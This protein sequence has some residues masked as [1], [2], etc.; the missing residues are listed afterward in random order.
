MTLAY[1][2]QN[3]FNFN[4][5]W[6]ATVTYD[7]SLGIRINSFKQFQNK[8]TND[9]TE[10][11]SPWHLLACSVSLY[12]AC[13]VSLLLACSVSLH[14]ACSVSLLLACSVSLYMACSVSLKMACS[15]LPHS[16]SLKPL[17]KGAV[18]HLQPQKLFMEANTILHTESK[19]S[20]FQGSVR[21]LKFSLH[22]VL[23]IMETLE[24]RTT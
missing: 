6:F 11:I 9:V 16:F 10:Y 8:R 22:K 20:R 12:K 2:A 1:L 3:Y 19:F 13:S 4:K 14:I 5:K 21:I 15:V 23:F 7:V 18:T 17:Y 24:L